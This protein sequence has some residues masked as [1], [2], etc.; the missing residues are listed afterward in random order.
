MRYGPNVDAVVPHYEMELPYGTDIKEDDRIASV[1]ELDGHVKTGPLVI[2]SVRHS[3]LNVRL[4]L[5]EGRPPR[6]A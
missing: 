4:L 2:D 1:T 6:G 3:D 5:V